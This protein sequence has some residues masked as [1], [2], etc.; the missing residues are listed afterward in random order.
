MARSAVERHG[1]SPPQRITDVRGE[2]PVHA[3]PEVTLGTRNDLRLVLIDHNNYQS[4]SVPA[5]SAGSF[6]PF[7]FGHSPA[8]S[9]DS[10]RKQER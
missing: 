9:S 10:S 3:K 5:L 4:L 8:N 2:S 1:S 6:S 7:K